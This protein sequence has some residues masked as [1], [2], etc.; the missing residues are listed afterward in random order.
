MV[1]NKHLGD[2]SSFVASLGRYEGPLETVT[3]NFHIGIQTMLHPLV[4]L[5][6]LCRDF[7]ELKYT[8]IELCHLRG[9]LLAIAKAGITESTTTR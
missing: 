6:L 9:I 5:L 4:K 8:P 7:C 1:F 3:V 2:G